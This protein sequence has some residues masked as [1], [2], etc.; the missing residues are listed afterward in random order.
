MEKDGVGGYTKVK[1]LTVKAEA[2]A[3]PKP[4]ATKRPEPI[5][6]AVVNTDTKVYKKATS[7]S[8]ATSVKKGT[9]VEIRQS[10]VGR[11]C[12]QVSQISEKHQCP[13]YTSR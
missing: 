10:P 8:A 1:Y 4:Q 11:Y 3:T 2:T 12:P 6:K 5:S 7:A 13:V 9:V